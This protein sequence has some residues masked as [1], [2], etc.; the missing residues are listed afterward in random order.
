M[1]KQAKAMLGV[2]ELDAVADKGFYNGEQVK[3]CDQADIRTYVA[4]PHTSRNQ[5]KGLFTKDDF[6]YNKERDSYGCRHA[7]ELTFR[8]E[9]EE[10]G[11]ATRYYATNAC[12]TCPIKAQCTENKRGRRITRWADEHLLEA[13]AERVQANAA[14]MKRRKELVEHIF[15]TMKRSMDQGYFLL[16]TRKK[17]AAEMSL[18]VLAYNLKRV[19]T[20]LGVPAL[21]AEIERSVGGVEGIVARLITLIVVPRSGQDRLRWWYRTSLGA[22]FSHSLPLELTPLRGPRSSRF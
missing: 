3:Q 14:I 22:D 4:K 6:V 9:T 15:G 20:I 12:G 21:I 16:R 8:F 11:R 5:H 2:E 1:A 17:V 13:M 18:T 19:I 10:K 7:A